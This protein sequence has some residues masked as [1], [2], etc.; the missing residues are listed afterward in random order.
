MMVVWT[1]ERRSALSRVRVN[2]TAHCDM[3][4]SSILSGIKL[5]FSSKDALTRMRLIYLLGCFHVRSQLEAVTTI[6]MQNSIND[7]EF[8]LAD[9]P[10]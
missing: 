3:R 7:D 10:T 6:C 1:N 2:P 9:R 4:A 5:L 8:F